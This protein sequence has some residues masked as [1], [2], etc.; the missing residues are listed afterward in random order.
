MIFPSNIE[1]NSIKENKNLIDL[2]IHFSKNHHLIKPTPSVI[3]AL[4]KK[5][6]ES[7][8]RS[9]LVLKHKNADS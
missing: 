8:Y 5:K 1:L 7:V 2:I 3:H 6:K 4:K 9:K